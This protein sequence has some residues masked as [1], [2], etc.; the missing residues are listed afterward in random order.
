MNSV[1]DALD[2]L[3][4]LW[5]L[6]LEKCHKIED[7]LANILN[8]VDTCGIEEA[9]YYGVVNNWIYAHIGD[10]IL[11]RVEHLSP[12][13]Q[14]NTVPSQYIQMLG[15]ALMGGTQHKLSTLLTFEN[16]Q[17]NNKEG[18]VDYGLRL[19]VLQ[20]R[21]GKATDWAGYRG[22]F[23]RSMVNRDLAGIMCSNY[24]SNCAQQVLIM[25]AKEAA[26]R[27]MELFTVRSKDTNK[28]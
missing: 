23:V 6:T 12:G 14:K 28:H 4:P 24:P 15:D 3:T 5:D 16:A 18:V 11:P 10:N 22:K 7:W 25:R 8:R 19:M 26:L 21:A 2:S 1:E 13:L 9:Q 17:Q 20:G 27:Q